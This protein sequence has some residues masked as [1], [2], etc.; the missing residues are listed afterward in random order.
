MDDWELVEGEVG[1]RMGLEIGLPF[2][3]TNCPPS[4][5]LKP[6]LML[7]PDPPDPLDG[8][9]PPKELMSTLLGAAEAELSSDEPRICCW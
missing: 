2:E 4:R 5:G 9:P 3:S 1:V 8:G 7:E 6:A